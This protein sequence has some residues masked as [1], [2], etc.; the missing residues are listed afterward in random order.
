MWVRTHIST[1]NGMRRADVLVRLKDE[2]IS[3]YSMPGNPR[4]PWCE[5]LVA[6][7]QPGDGTALYDITGDGRLDIVTG[8]GY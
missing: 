4:D 6:E 3:W 5:S 8:T 1:D 7:V 2:P